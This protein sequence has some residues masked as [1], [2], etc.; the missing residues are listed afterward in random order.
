VKQRADLQSAYDEW[1]KVYDTD[2]K[3]L[4][5][6]DDMITPA[7]FPPLADRDVLDFG[8]GTGRHTVRLVAAGARVT[9]VDASKGMLDVA[10]RRVGDAAKLIHDT[11]VPAGSFDVVLCTLVVEHHAHLR[12]VFEQLSSVLRDGGTAIVSDI[13]PSMRAAGTQ[14]NFTSSDGVDV[15]PPSFIHPLEEWVTAAAH[16][17]WRIDA[18]AEHDGTAALIAQ[19]PR[20]QKYLGKPMLVTLRATKRTA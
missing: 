5:A 4:V 11:K 10:G 8:C 15:L 2:L 1:S 17:G 18:L 19:T 14:A 16:A 6:L 9:A 7:L 20:A 13:H 12:D 3:P